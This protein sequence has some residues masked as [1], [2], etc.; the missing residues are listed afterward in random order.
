M[1]KRATVQGV[2]SARM[3]W[4]YMVAALESEGNIG[5]TLYPN[6]LL[7]PTDPTLGYSTWELP[8]GFSPGSP[9]LNDAES[10]LNFA[11]TR[12]FIEFRENDGHKFSLS[13][14]S[15]HAKKDTWNA[16]RGAK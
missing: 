1:S 2:G 15:L 7:G 13:N 3:R 14:L 6:R 9:A 12:T 8:G 11:A 16:L 5:V 4:G 10:P